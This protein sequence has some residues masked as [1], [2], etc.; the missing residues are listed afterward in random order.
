MRFLIVALIGCATSTTTTKPTS[1]RGTLPELDYFVG[2]WRA[3]AKNPATGQTFVLDY[4][5]APMLRGRWYAGTGSAAALD[6]DIYDLWGKDP[7]T[8]EIV[9]TIFDS[10]QTSGTVRSKGWSGDVLVL[11]GDVATSGGRATVRETITKQGPDEFHAVW[12]AKDGEAWSA[13]S[14]EILKRQR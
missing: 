4:T 12:E 7:V 2:T 13:Y 3:E 9:R 5:V 14:V 10:A 11:E 1:T 6:L 8:G